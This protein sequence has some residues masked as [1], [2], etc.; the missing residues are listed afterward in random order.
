MK[1]T[2]EKLDVYA[3]A[4]SHLGSLETGLNE[5]FGEIIGLIYKTFGNE[6]GSWWHSDADTLEGDI[7]T[8]DSFA[9][10]DL[11]NDNNTDVGIEYRSDGT[12]SNPMYTDG[13]NYSWSFPVKWL[14]WTDEQIENSS[15]MRLKK[16]KKKTKNAK[17]VEK[18]MIN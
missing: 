10:E 11:I 13:W 3:K 8:I 18:K 2:K 12:D 5:R 14:L 15:A 1:Y 9:I 16:T 7:G 6:L 17:I 4:L